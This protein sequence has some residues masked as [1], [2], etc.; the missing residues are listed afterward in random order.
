MNI[1]D[2]SKI[3]FIENEI[4]YSSSGSLGSAVSKYSESAK[5]GNSRKGFAS[6]SK[7]KRKQIAKR[8]GVARKVAAENGSAP[9]Y[10]IIGQKGGKAGSKSK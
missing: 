2:N 4:C 5:S 8:G 9:S 6:M 3:F 1:L 7:E 10:S